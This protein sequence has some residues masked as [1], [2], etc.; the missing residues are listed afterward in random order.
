MH[1]FLRN[2]ID[3]LTG[4]SMS[5]EEFN[6]LKDAFTTKTVKKKQYLLHE[7]SVC[8]YMGFIVKGAMRKYLIDDKGNEHIVRF[9]I[10]E[11]WMSDRESFTM[12]RPSRYNIDAV[13]DT[14]LLVATNEKLSRLKDVSPLFIK[15]SQILDE[16]SYAASE[17]RIEAS[18]ILTAE[19][20]LVQLMESYPAFLQR[21][22][23]TMIA[24]YLGLTPETLS[25][26][27]KQVLS[28]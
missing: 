11:W 21:F 13:E 3:K 12:L 22:P 9:G 26:V 5:D 6:H 7:G 28:K 17:S 24:S 4:A 1:D 18:L 15:M 2:Y 23:Q 10:E 16:K 19:E 27:R 8:K 20:K 14:E 25:R